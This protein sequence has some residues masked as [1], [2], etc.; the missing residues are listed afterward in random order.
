MVCSTPQRKTG[1]SARGGERE[2]PFSEVPPSR[3]V[4]ICIKAPRF[5]SNAA[6]S[7]ILLPPWHPCRTFSMEPVDWLELSAPEGVP[8]PFLLE[9][10]GAYQLFDSLELNPRIVLAVGNQAKA[11]FLLGLGPACLIPGSGRGINLRLF[12]LSST[13]I[14][15]CQMHNLSEIKHVVPSAPM[16][17]CHQHLLDSLF[18]AS[19]PRELGRFVLGLYWHML[20]P[21]A[22][23]ILLFLDD[24]GG[25]DAVIETLA[26]WALRSKLVQ[27]PPRI[28]ILYNEHTGFNLRQF[29]SQLR[30]RLRVSLLSRLSP[31]P[32]ATGPDVAFD[33]EV[34]FES[35][36]VLKITD[37]APSIVLFEI[38]ESFDLRYDAGLAFS[39]EHVKYLLQ[40]A[41][42][43]SCRSQK[44]PFNLY[45]ASRLQNPVSERLECH[46]AEFLK[47]SKRLGIDQASVIASALD[48]DAHPPGMHCQRA[49]VISH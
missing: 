21:L 18:S 35:V 37:D 24:L 7:R 36:R 48:V 19:L 4:N 40:Q 22:S 28:I 45:Q 38:E 33:G 8:Y 3:F 1:S 32:V 17:Y 31:S 6:G 5:N 26:A 41:V 14:F 10:Q 39:G 25:P 47:A 30:R 9:H 20:A 23:T 15:D 46:V 42:F 12:P 43:N 2:K 34:S 27:S 11:Q 49:S 29:Q 16:G 44:V 13:V